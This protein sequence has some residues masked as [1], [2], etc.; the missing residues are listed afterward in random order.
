MAPR[1]RFSLVNGF[2]KVTVG[3]AAIAI[4]ALYWNWSAAPAPTGSQTTGAT[5]PPLSATTAKTATTGA[6][7]P[8]ERTDASPPTTAVT[9]DAGTP[10]AKLRGRVIDVFGVG[11]AGVALTVGDRGA[12]RSVA[13][14]LHSGVGGAFELASSVAADT[15]VSSDPR[16]STV[17]AGSTR[18]R[19]PNLSTVV[20][21]PRVEIGGRVVNSDGKPLP[22][23]SVQV[24]LPSHL[25]A[26]LGILLDYSANVS[27]QASS[28]QHG[29]FVLRDVPAVAQGQ[30]SITLGG[31]L[32]RFVELP[33]ASTELLEVVLDRPEAGTGVV[34]G[35]VVDAFGAFVAGARVSAGGEVS[36]TDDR[37][38]FT[39]DL[40]NGK[41]LH[42]I[43][44]IAK[45]M[46]PAVLVPELDPEGQPKWPARVTL[47]LGQAPLSIRGQVID[48]N[49]QPVAGAKVWIDDPLVVGKQGALIA[50]TFLSREDRPFWAF[51]LTDIAGRF[52][53][54]GLLDRAYIV[55]ALD[56]ATLMAV[57]Q[58]GVQAGN[59]GVEIQLAC[60]TYPELRGRVV[61]GD[62]SAIS[63]VSV[64]LIRMA[65]SVE[66]PG[67]AN[68]SHF[69]WT[70][71][72]PI[73]TNQ[74]GEFVFKN[75]PTEGV[76]VNATG[77]SILFAWKRVEPDIDPTAFVLQAD[78]RMHLQVELATP[79]D[80]ADAVKILK[81]TG[82]HMLLVVMRGAS[83]TQNFKAALL[84]GRSQVLTL[85]EGATTAVFFK[86]DVE[87]GRMPVQLQAGQVN[88][89]RF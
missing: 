81:A 52:R 8:L 5:N 10:P 19:D 4:A 41:T 24:H 35:L 33:P 80:R 26:D 76:E 30:L 34:E 13:S 59:S 42:R 1:P 72:T 85:G 18:V 79:T 77:D 40:S 48:R 64:T 62:G 56:P 23:A 68:S 12:S 84:A 25:G 15:I 55:R 69:E 36:K 83:R 27:W 28:D 37:G 11:I 6:E 61:A 39:I 82:R 74:N 75:V 63:G 20:V 53:L 17:L 57:T 49:R 86:G 47:R 50:E 71:T 87:V 67:P 73:T 9:T 43:V 46:Q 21:A 66:I 65:L 32:S 14:D 88:T 29:R 38:A 2:G 58:E 45:G 44:A 51:V 60:A 70:S 22:E 78:R 16:W 31:Y 89:I 3:L 7:R 54:D